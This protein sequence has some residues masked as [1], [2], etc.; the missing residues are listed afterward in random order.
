MAKKQSSLFPE[1]TGGPNCPVTCPKCSMPLEE[2]T[3]VCWMC[4]EPIITKISEEQKQQ[5][6][7]ACLKDIVKLCNRTTPGNTSHNIAAI[8]AMALQT[9]SILSNDSK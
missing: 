6:T 8:R 1:E 7:N 2:E 9:L 5:L 4:S 3:T